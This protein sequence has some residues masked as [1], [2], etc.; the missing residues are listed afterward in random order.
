MQNQ[1]TTTATWNSFQIEHINIQSH[2]NSSCIDFRIE[3][4][5]IH[6]DRQTDRQR[7]IETDRQTDRQ[8][9]Q[10]DRQTDRT[11]QD[12]TGQERTGQART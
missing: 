8:T 10:T 6:T 5:C 3:Y 4:L 2:G 9:E 1:T 12:K 11:G 7:D